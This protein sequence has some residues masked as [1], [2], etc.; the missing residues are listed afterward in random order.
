MFESDYS[1][2]AKKWLAA[3][4]RLLASEQRIGDLFLDMMFS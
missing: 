2:A 1:K 4:E 3:E